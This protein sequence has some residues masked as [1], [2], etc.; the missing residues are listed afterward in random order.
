MQPATM[1]SAAQR[2]RLVA[3]VLFDAQRFDALAFSRDSR[4]MHACTHY[5]GYHRHRYELKTRR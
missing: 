3:R 1:V 4:G 5:A 2:L